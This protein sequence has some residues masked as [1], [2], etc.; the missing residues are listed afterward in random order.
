[1]ENEETVPAIA[2]TEMTTKVSDVLVSDGGN[3]FGTCD[4]AAAE[5][6][7]SAFVNNFEAD[8][9]IPGYDDY[10]AANTPFALFG[11]TGLED[12]GGFSK[13]LVPK[14][15]KGYYKKADFAGLFKSEYKCPVDV[16][17][18]VDQRNVERP[19]NI[20]VGAYDADNSQSSIAAVEAREALTVKYAGAGV[21]ELS[22]PAS[23]IRI[24]DLSG[25]MVA[26]QA[27]SRIDLSAYASG[28]YIVNVDGCTAK[29]VK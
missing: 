20:S 23:D 24:Y 13:V 17:D 11:R 6:G 26:R 21:Y 9:I 1:M 5:E 29:L 14:T 3:I 27:G 8:V 15:L 16:D 28:L 22:A 2:L 12:K 25:R 7:G 10:S 18:M 19:E 4:F